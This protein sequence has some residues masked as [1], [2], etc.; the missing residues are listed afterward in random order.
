MNAK[1]SFFKFNQFVIDK[2]DVVEIKVGVLGGY[3]GNAMIEYCKKAN[4]NIILTNTHTISAI[5]P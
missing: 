5:N 3:R 4:V 1:L 2:F